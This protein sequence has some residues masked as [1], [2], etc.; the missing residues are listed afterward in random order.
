MKLPKKLKI[1]SVAL[2]EIKE[3]QHRIKLETDRELKERKAIILELESRVTN[4]KKV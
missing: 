2:I 1:E 4:R 3:E